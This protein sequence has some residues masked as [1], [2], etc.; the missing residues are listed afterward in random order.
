MVRVFPFVVIASSVSA[1]RLPLSTSFAC[2][3]KLV[4]STTHFI[5]H[6]A[7]GDVSMTGELCLALAN[8]GLGDECATLSQQFCDGLTEAVKGN[9][10]STPIPCSHRQTCIEYKGPPVPGVRYSFAKS[11]DM[12]RAAGAALASNYTIVFS[13][14]QPQAGDHVTVVLNGMHSLHKHK[15]KWN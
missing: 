13:N 4:A 2:A 7:M 10:V 9:K 12:V 3:T 8:A 15:L 6:W 14:E 5:H 11:N 1:F